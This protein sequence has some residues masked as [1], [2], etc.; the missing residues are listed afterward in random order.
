MG[1]PIGVFLLFAA[2][3][4]GM[5]ACG[6]FNPEISGSHAAS[7]CAVSG[8]AVRD[9]AQKKEQ[10]E[11]KKR[12]QTNH[13][14]K[15]KDVT[16]ALHRSKKKQ[17]HSICKEKDKWY[18]KGKTRYALTDLDQ[19]GYLEIFVSDAHGSVSL[20][21]VKESGDGLE[22]WQTPDEKLAFLEN[23]M[24]VYWDEKSEVWHLDVSGGD[25]SE[26][27]AGL[28]CCR[29]D[30][31]VKDNSMYA[32]EYKDAAKQFQGMEKR[33]MCF[34][35]E[36]VSSE[37]YQEEL[38][39]ME[40][41]VETA[42]DLTDWERKI[43]AGEREQL[44]L[45]ARETHKSLRRKR[46]DFSWNT[47]FYAVT[48]LDRDGQVECLEA[49]LIGSGIVR[50]Y[51]SLY[52]VLPEKRELAMAACISD[53][54]IP[55]GT[56]VSG[57]FVTYGIGEK[58]AVWQDKQTGQNYYVF[59][60]GMNYGEEE[61]KEYQFSLKN[62]CFQMTEIKKEIREIAVKKSDIHLKWALSIPITACEDYRYEELVV[63]WLGF[64]E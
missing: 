27:A 24:P 4:F 61:I 55:A 49:T 57:G 9:E 28:D 12:V 52:E 23:P 18:K 21:E 36:E 2:M 14:A 45:V 50:S 47:L 64:G 32:V 16:A 41:Q 44:Q 20:F 39:Y 63:S 37:D 5:T 58:I 7:G 46:S 1:K 48:D 40:F 19:D 11:T 62:H 56:N 60:A 13:L 34:D 53:T 31:S 15:R 43:S 17:I 54:G 38:S 33:Y 3:L 8:Q 6:S 30:L 59:Q 29:Y 35:T 26:Q 25:E 10:K 51:Y 22:M 42:L